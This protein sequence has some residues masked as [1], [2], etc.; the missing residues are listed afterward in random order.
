MRPTA[1]VVE[2]EI[3]DIIAG[4]EIQKSQRLQYPV[5]L[6]SIRPRLPDQTAG[7]SSLTFQLTRVVSSVVR[8]TDVVGCTSPGTVVHVLLVDAD[9]GELP[10]VIRR[11]RDEVDRHRFAI[12]GAR[13]TIDLAIG[14]ASFP[15]GASQLSELR[16]Q[17]DAQAAA[18]LS[19]NGVESDTGPDRDG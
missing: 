10:I 16:L 13:V 4:L 14:A 3:L 2:E 15:A 12:D 1:A 5:S 7:A 8:T 18:G 9:P 19:T 17:A 6:L 11:I